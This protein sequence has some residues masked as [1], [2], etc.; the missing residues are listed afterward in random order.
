MYQIKLLLLDRLIQDREL[1]LLDG[2]RLLSQERYTAAR[3]AAGLS[4][5]EMEER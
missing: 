5:E 4:E 1:D 3:V 2:T